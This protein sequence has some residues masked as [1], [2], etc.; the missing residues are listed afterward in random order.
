LFFKIADGISEIPKPSHIQ[1]VEAPPPGG[2][3][4]AGAP[5]QPL[6]VL[7][8]LLAVPV[9]IF[10][11]PVFFYILD[12]WT[13]LIQM[14]QRPFGQYLVT[15]DGEQWFPFFHLVYYGLVKIAGERYSLLVLINCLGTGVN[16]FLLYT[17]FRRR[18]EFGLAFTLSLVYVMDAAHH[19]T[20]WNAFY[21]GYLL[22]L[23]FFLGALLLT[24]GYRQA[25]SGGKLWGIGVCAALSVLSHNYPLVGL[26]ALPLYILLLG[27][28]GSR[29]AFWAVAGVVGL[30]YVLFAVGYFRF[31][32][33][34]AAA[35]RN[36]QVFSGLPGPAYFLHLVCGAFLSP[37]FYLFWGHYHFPL[38][39]YVAGAALL[40]ACLAVIWRWGGR[41]DHRLALWALAANVLPF[42]LVSLTRYQ[43]SVSQAFV[44]RYDIF[45][46]VGAL[47]LVGLAWRLAAPRLPSRRWAGA[48]AGIVLAVMVYGQ[49]FSLP[50]WTAKYR[51]MSRLA[52]KCYAGPTHGAGAAPPLTPEEY[53]KFCPDA[54]PSITP[55][56]VRA[57]RRLL[58]G[59]PEKL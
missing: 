16:A 34:P 28:R 32:G 45:T 49:L 58:G 8:V 13:A 43:R 48:L 31:A 50:I 40:T 5:V 20:A 42:F 59:A 15:P 54:Y 14:A 1:P 41:E 33:L 22:S 52:R 37:F 9:I 7:L 21:F 35:S 30:V 10:W 53:R 56:Q 47:L 27:D 19:A 44:A 11:R 17:F 23:G 18:W 26:L 55:G 2:P 29:R 3:D 38:G 4:P 39:A 25:P 12:D 51:E 36:F 24:D 57:V 6:L 46:L